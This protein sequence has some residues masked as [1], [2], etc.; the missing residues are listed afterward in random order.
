MYNI[1]IYRIDGHKYLCLCGINTLIGLIGRLEQ[2]KWWENW[3][4]TYLT[5]KVGHEHL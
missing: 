4:V 1:Y 2:S 5:S 3:D